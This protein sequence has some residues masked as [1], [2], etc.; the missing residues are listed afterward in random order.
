MHTLQR[1]AV[2][3][4][5]LLLPMN[6]K[7]LVIPIID[8]QYNKS[9]I[10]AYTRRACSATLTLAIDSNIM[11]Q[12]SCC[13]LVCNATRQVNTSATH[14]IATLCFELTFVLACDRFE[15]ASFGLK[16]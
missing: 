16:V 10:N 7:L 13:A 5:M 6:T 9:Y 4:S 3:H 14:S 8:L 11:P 2:T 12:D 15:P 1:S